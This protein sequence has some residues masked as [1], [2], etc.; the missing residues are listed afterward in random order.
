MT[1]K[2]L[3]RSLAALALS[4]ATVLAYAQSGPVLMTINGS[5]IYTSQV[6]EMVSM[7]VA[8]GSKDSPEL[9]QNLLSEFG[10]NIN[11]IRA[12]EGLT[13]SS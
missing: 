4:S 10:H 9:R 1:F 11:N 5:K 3:L 7:A 13:R 12:I 2:T 8:N 6:N